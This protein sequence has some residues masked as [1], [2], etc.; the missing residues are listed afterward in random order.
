M[1]EEKCCN[2]CLYYNVEQGVCSKDGTNR[3]SFE[4]ENC[5]RWVDWEMEFYR[6]KSHE[7]NHKA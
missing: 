4:G 1:E 7:K 3:Y 6:G 5:E 2:T